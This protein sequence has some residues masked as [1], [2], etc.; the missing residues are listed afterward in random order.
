M[1]IVDFLRNYFSN[2]VYLISNS[3]P[4]V[5]DEEHVLNH[6]FRLNAVPRL[7]DHL[8]ASSKEKLFQLSISNF[9]CSHCGAGKGQLDTLKVLSKHKANLWMKNHRGDL[10]LHEAV[11]S[12]RKDLVRW[13]LAQKPRAADAANNDGRCPLHIACINN[14]VE[15]CKVN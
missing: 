13:L 8:T 6:M 14:H 5:E 2:N 1:E 10:P 4:R 3:L 11:H 12:G 9:S 7:K 15:M